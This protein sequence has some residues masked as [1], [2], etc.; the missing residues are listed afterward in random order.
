MW[1]SRRNR[2]LNQEA[3]QS[4]FHCREST[5]NSESPQSMERSGKKQN[6]GKYGRQR[7]RIGLLTA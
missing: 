3:G 7:L 4:F 1:D 6:S 5:Q 2:L